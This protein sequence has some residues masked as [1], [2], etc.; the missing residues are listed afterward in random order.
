MTTITTTMMVTTK[1]IKAE[2][3]VGRQI[4][5]LETNA[6]YFFFLPLYFTDP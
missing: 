1:K 5:W 6:E 2:K 4:V 3:H